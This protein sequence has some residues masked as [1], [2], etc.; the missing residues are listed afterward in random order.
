MSLS[1]GVFDDMFWDQHHLFTHLTYILSGRLSVIMN[2]KISFS[3][4][5]FAGHPCAG[6]MLIF[7]VFISFLLMA[8][9]GGGPT[10]DGVNSGL[11][12]YCRVGMM[13]A[14]QKVIYPI[15]SVMKERFAP[16]STIG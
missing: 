5:N 15:V 16:N 9:P 7:S 11:S 10:L 2:N 3:F 1:V 8:P 13:W 6:A 14:R 4:L 12:T